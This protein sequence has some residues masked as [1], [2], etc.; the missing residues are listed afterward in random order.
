LDQAI[1]S[2]VADV[3]P[4]ST[5]L[6]TTV[7]R[8]RWRNPGSCRPDHLSSSSKK[9]TVMF[10]TSPP[11][12]AMGLAEQRRHD[13]V[14]AAG[15]QPA[16]AGP[17]GL[18]RLQVVHAARARLR[19]FAPCP[20]A[21]SIAGRSAFERSKRA[22]AA[23]WIHGRPHLAASLAAAVVASAGAFVATL[24]VGPATVAYPAP[25]G[26]AADAATNTAGPAIKVGSGPWSIAITPNGKTAYVANHDD[27]TVTP[28]HI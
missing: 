24:L 12:I 17:V 21:S 26:R 4:K 19:R 5:Y 7:S 6:G 25:S 20:H 13:L 11:F 3:V 22:H 18:D 23:A 8:P 16:D 27:G 2:G 10:N 1:G 14:A 9:G 28:I 15:K